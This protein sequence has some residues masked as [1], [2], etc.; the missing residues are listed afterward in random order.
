MKVKNLDDMTA[1]LQKKGMNHQMYYQYTNLENA[2]NIIQSGYW[3]L[4]LG[5]I[6]N[7]KQELKKG[8]EDKWNKTYISSFSYGAGENIAMWGIYCIP[9]SDAVRIGI[10]GK[11]MRDW[12]SNIESIYL[13]N[14]E[15][16]NRFEYSDEIKIKPILTDIG[17]ISLEGSEY[18]I[19]RGKDKIEFE[20]PLSFSEINT[21]D[22][23]TGYIKNAAWSYENEVRIK[24][25]LKDE[26]MNQT[27]AIKI[28]EEIRNGFELT[29][30]PWCVEVVKS[31]ANNKLRL[32]NLQFEFAAYNDS[33]FRG[34]VDLKNICSYC[35]Y[36]YEKSE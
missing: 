17:Y 19:K 9:W 31:M 29:A 26:I 27:I 24:I 33:L 2:I 28:P 23:I 3:H 12:I 35:N 15:A 7:D 8:T 6:M 1:Y 20:T 18:S 11:H 36:T 34:L 14:R 5:D 4:S 13:V 25:E 30:G 21:C 16:N 32:K 22:K 10:R